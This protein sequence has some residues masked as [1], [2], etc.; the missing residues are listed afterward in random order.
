MFSLTS[1][2]PSLALIPGT[3]EWAGGA[4]VFTVTAGG[5][6]AL[7]ASAEVLG[8]GAPQDNLDALELLLC[9]DAEYCAQMH[10][11]LSPSSAGPEEADEPEEEDDDD[12]PDDPEDDE[13]GA[14]LQSR[15]LPAHSL[16]AILSET[17]RPV[18]TGVEF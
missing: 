14:M 9:D 4:D 8:L 7:F 1:D 18:L 6:P 12:S 2:S 5:E 15:A 17:P 3:S 10:G 11:I 13:E 16:Q